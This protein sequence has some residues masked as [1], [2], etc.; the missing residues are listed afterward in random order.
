MGS[1]YVNN[2]TVAFRKHHPY[3]PGMW[4]KWLHGTLKSNQP[5]TIYD[6]EFGM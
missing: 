4:E 1:L 6:F 2:H 5:V 3:K